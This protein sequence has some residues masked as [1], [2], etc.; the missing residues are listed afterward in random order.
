MPVSDF[1][2]LLQDDVTKNQVHKV[3]GLTHSQHPRRRGGRRNRLISHMSMLHERATK[4]GPLQSDKTVEDRKP[5]GL[6]N[7]D[8]LAIKQDI[9]TQILVIFGLRCFKALNVQIHSFKGVLKQLYGRI[10]NNV[11]H[12][13]SKNYF[14][15]LLSFSL[16]LLSHMKLLKVNLAFCLMNIP[17]KPQA[18]MSSSLKM[19]ANKPVP[20]SMP[21]A[22]SSM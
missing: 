2:N 21:L 17:N 20:P 6:K 19:E 14:P 10:T 12:S 3:D 7:M 15:A 4:F 18:A 8:D 5:N 16:A 9:Y 13:L 11:F 1:F 22:F